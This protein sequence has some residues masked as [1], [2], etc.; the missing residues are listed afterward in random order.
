MASHF[1]LNVCAHHAFSGDEIQELSGKAYT[2][3]TV[4]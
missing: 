1:L 3:N 2:F 4:A